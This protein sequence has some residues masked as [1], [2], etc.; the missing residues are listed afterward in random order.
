[1]L[2]LAGIEVPAPGVE[3][4]TKGTEGNTQGGNSDGLGY[5]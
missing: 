2:E 3:I 4:K 5:Y 1:M